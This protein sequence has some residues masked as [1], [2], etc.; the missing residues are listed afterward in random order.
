[1]I[2]PLL[3]AVAA[4]FFPFLETRAEP[5]N[6]YEWMA[7]APIVA[8][9]EIVS[10]DAR[11]AEFRVEACLRGEL[12]GGAV[13]LVNRRRANRDRENGTPALEF[14]TGRRYVLLLRAAPEAKKSGLRQF[15]LV[16]GTLG[17]REFPAEGGAALDRAL[18]TFADVQARKD[19]A[20]A[21][22]AFR[23]FLEDSNPYLVDASLDLHLKFRRVRTDE[24]P[25]ARDLLRSPRPDVRRRASELVRL[26]LDRDDLA[27]EAGA[28]AVDDLI[29]AA[30]TDERPDVRAAATS[31]L[32]ASRTPAATEALREIARDDPEQAVR[33]EAERAL[34]DRGER[35]APVD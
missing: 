35:P 14:E 9:G 8:T 31:A 34:V 5:S 28:L 29:A 19:D 13:A 22:R 32:A 16:R 23:S 15:D 27:P 18:E 11:W 21:W 24:L 20:E 2:R 25:A 7:I 30:R 6:F 10:D 3:C 26:I 12:P 4:S 33:Y 1:M 17:A